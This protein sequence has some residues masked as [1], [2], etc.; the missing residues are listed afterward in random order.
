[1]T[2]LITGGTGFLGSYFARYALLQ[3]PLEQ[4]VILDR[5]IDRSRISD[6]LDRVTVIEGDVA[7][8]GLIRKVIT[9]HDVDR[10]AHYAFILGSPKPDMMLPYIQVQCVGTTNV[11]EAARITGVKRVLFC[12]S[13]AAYGK[14]Q[15]PLLTEDLAVNP[16]DPYGACKAWGEALGRHYAEQLGLDVVSL[17]FGSTY[18]LGRGWRGSYSSGLLNA[19]T[20][21]HYMARVEDAVRGRPVELPR[22]DAL[23]DW[24]YA[25]D[26]A[27]AAWRALTQPRL[28]HRLYNVCSERAAVG[29]FTRALRKLLPGADIRTSPTEMPGNAYAPMSNERLVK[30][31]G[32]APAYTL[33]GGVRDYIERIRTHDAYHPESA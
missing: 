16:S 11:F 18:G 20:Q 5:Y 23:A 8:F 31:L 27:Q 7:D 17:R 25:A 14:Q 12:S 9:G 15:A 6:I 3:Q 28:T 30:D 33:E 4:L 26:A 13:V 19:P 32:F 2:I 21:L 1:L 24:T 29:E 22:D 10:I